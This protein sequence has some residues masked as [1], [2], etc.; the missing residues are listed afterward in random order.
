M[1]RSRSWIALLFIA[2]IALG[3]GSVAENGNGP[4]ARTLKVEH[5]F[6][7]IYPIK[8]VCTTGMVADLA[9]NIGGAHV[10]VD[11]LMR[12]D[13]DPHLY[14]A[15]TGDTAKL[16]A[17]DLIFYSG[18]HLEGKMTEIFNSVEKL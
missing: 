5:A 6:K 13:V 7:G 12:Q 10:E 8:T 15:S 1:K 18:L 14:K 3:C 11:Q 2:A 4:Q 9:R 16:E 17:G